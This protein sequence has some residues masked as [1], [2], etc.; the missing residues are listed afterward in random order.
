MTFDPHSPVDR[1][2]LIAELVCATGADTR[3]APPGAS[4]AP[5]PTADARADLSALARCLPALQGSAMPL[6]RIPGGQSAGSPAE[7]VQPW[8][9][10]ARRALRRLAA[11]RETH[12]GHVLVLLCAYVRLGEE[13]RAGTEWLVTIRSMLLPGALRPRSGPQLAASVALG[14][15]LVAQAC[16]AYASAQEV[17]S[18]GRWLGADLEEIATL[19]RGDRVERTPPR[20]AP[21]PGCRA[22]RT[23]DWVAERGC[24]SNE[25]AV[26]CS[27]PRAPRCSQPVSATWSLLLG[28]V[29]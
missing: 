22:L 23:V 16:E 1:A 19:I 18:D 24:A 26:E 13:Q 15:R 20:P 27:W 2:R 6:L 7:H 11:L 4:P 8:L 3:P 29:A 28:M 10:G 14:E 25:T 17:E 21:A 9:S 5:S 12:Y